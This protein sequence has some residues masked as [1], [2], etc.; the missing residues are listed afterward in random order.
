VQNGRRTIY[1]RNNS[2]DNQ[3]GSSSGSVDFWF[4]VQNLQIQE[5]QK[6]MMPTLFIVSLIY[7]TKKVRT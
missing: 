3:C 5:G 7:A 1:K 6:K 2:D 4:I